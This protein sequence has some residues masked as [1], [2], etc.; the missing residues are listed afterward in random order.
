MRANATTKDLVKE[1]SSLKA[2]LKSLSASMEAEATNGVG[3]ALSQIETKSKEAID[4]VIQ[5][6]QAFI[7]E[8]ADDA[9]AAA[10]ALMKNS[11]KL[12]TE[13]TETLV[14]TVKE[15]PLASLAAIVGVGFLA[16]YLCRRS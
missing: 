13:A 11:A 4:E 9:K 10:K 12:R 3:G 15:R 8:Y 1:I 2:Q 16:G 14:E 6:A 5:S 7:D